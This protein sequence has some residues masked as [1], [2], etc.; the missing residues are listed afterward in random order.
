MNSLGQRSP[1]PEPDPKL[2]ESA[3][4]K[5]LEMAHS[6]GISTSEFIQMLDSG[7]R[8]LDFVNASETGPDSDHAGDWDS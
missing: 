6:Q 7:M 1:S 4:G 2:V 3:I 8:I 5:V